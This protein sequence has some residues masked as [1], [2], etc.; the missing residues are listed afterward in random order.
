MSKEFDA[1]R[2]ELAENTFPIKQ[3]KEDIKLLASHSRTCFC[4]G[5]DAAVK[6]CRDERDKLLAENKRLT[7]EKNSLIDSFE[8]L[9]K[10]INETAIGEKVGE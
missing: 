2:D 7:A 6:L 3:Q 8:K 10:A 5:F 1:I 9:Q 4:M